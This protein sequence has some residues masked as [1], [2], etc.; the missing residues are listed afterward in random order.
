MMCDA[1]IA[2]RYQRYY[3]MQKNTS[4]SLQQLQSH[5]S[6]SS[7]YY[8]TSTIASTIAIASAV[9]GHDDISFSLVSF[10]VVSETL[11]ADE[12]LHLSECCIRISITSS[13]SYTVYS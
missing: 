2:C 12:T 10:P 5:T 1:L 11:Y 13:S 4:Q 8:C 6:T 3:T 9:R 7:L